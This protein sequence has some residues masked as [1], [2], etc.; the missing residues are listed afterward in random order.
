MSRQLAS[1]LKYLHS[2]GICHRDIKPENILYNSQTGEIKVIDLDVCGVKKYRE[3]EFDL[4]TNTGTLLY[5]APESFGVGYSEKVD[6]WSVGVM[7]Y[8]L[9][10]GEVPLKAEYEK[11]FLANLKNEDVDF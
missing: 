6:V 10:V 5:R 1:V 3:E 2:E 7:M 8:E 11:D 4:W 9:V